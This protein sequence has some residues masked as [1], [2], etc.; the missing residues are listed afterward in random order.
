MVVDC[1]GCIY[2]R[3]VGFGCM[4]CHWALDNP[5]FCRLAS[6]EN[7]T[8]KI[9]KKEMN[10]QLNKINNEKALQ[11][12]REGKNDPEIALVFGVTNSAVSRWR[13]V[14]SL[15]ANIPLE[16]KRTRS[17][18]TSQGNIT[19]PPPP[20]T[21]QDLPQNIDMDPIIFAAFKMAEKIADSEGIEV[22]QKWRKLMDAVQQHVS[23]LEEYIEMGDEEK[24]CATTLA[25]LA[26][27]GEINEKK[28]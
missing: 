5:P 16:K 27:V 4:A 7:C 19:P 8:Y 22:P 14:R 18:V 6:A 2:W 24:A 21:V 20:E 15:Q 17:R 11:L 23:R 25:A 13:R 3:H 9:T 1:T 12:Y 28:A 10:E 26:A